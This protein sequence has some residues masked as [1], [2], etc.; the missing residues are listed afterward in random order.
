MSKYERVK[1][2]TDRLSKNRH[3]ETPRESIGEPRESYGVLGL[4]F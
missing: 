4:L 2:K 3:K 1:N